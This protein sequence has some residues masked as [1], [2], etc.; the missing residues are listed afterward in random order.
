[1]LPE[2]GRMTVRQGRRDPDAVLAA[3]PLFRGLAAHER[4]HLAE[5]LR[6][7]RYRRGQTIFTEGEPGR[8]LV[9]LLRGQVKVV[10]STAEGDEAIVALFGPGDF[11]GEMSLLDDQ[12]RSATVI[13]LEPVEAL[14]LHRQDFRAFLREHVDAAERILAVLAG[15]IRRLDNQLR[16][17]YFLDLPGRLAQKLLELGTERGIRTA[18][19][20]QINLPLTQSDLASMVGASRQRVNRILSDWRQQGI[21]RIDRR[22]VTI[23][24]PDYFQRQLV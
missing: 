23:L 7:R 11:F 24:R 15:H 3:I 10:L 12:P 16:R 20:I 19:G 2:Q 22:A 21:I 13:A 17:T 5:C 9:I 4:A 18:E 6:L 8:Y 14:V 1:M